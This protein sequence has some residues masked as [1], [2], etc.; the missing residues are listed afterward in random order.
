MLSVDSI[1][2][3]YKGSPEN[4]FIIIWLSGKSKLLFEYIPRSPDGFGRPEVSESIECEIEN[5]LQYFD[6][7]IQK[8]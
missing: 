5:G 6:E 1:F 2:K 3:K 7:F 4:P 8:L